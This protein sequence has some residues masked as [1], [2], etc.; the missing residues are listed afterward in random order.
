ME[1]QHNY[2][3]LE[4][5]N[6]ERNFRYKTSLIQ[7]PFSVSKTKVVVNNIWIRNAWASESNASKTKAR[8]W[9]SIS[10]RCYHQWWKLWIP[11]SFCNERL[12]KHAILVESL[13]LHQI[14]SQEDHHHLRSSP[15]L[16]HNL[17]LEEGPFLFT[18]W[19]T[20]T[21]QVVTFMPIFVFFFHKTYTFSLHRKNYSLRS[22]ALLEGNKFFHS[23]LEY[24]SALLGYYNLV[25]CLEETRLR[26]FRIK[27]KGLF[28]FRKKKTRIKH[29]SAEEDAKE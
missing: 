1:T 19:T 13:F 14:I 25:P 10:L 17:W 4:K 20:T 3:T 28:L 21:K 22:E 9:E 26:D 6:R 27:S 23:S 29:H 11:S 2:F 15:A 12:Q 7:K 16:I 18:S 8:H 24:F 5:R